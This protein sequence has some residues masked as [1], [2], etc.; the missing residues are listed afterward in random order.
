MLIAVLAV[1]CTPVTGI[2]ARGG[3]AQEPVHRLDVVSMLHLHP[4]A[5]A[6]LVADTSTFADILA[7]R[8]RRSGIDSRALD[9]SDLV[10]RHDL[11]VEVTVRDNGA[12]RYVDGR[13]P[14]KALLSSIEGKARHR[15]VLFPARLV[16]DRHTR[17]TLGTV[18]WR[19]EPSE[20]GS[21]LAYGVLRY[22]ADARGFPGHRLAG[23]LVAELDR[24]GVHGAEAGVN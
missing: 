2:G 1:A 4:A 21:P 9:V 23:E 3:S 10:R 14:E 15:L 20:G 22:T 13:L 12:S 16:V 17:A 8:L 18:D 24:L 6:R 7:R 5:D 11:P 19:L